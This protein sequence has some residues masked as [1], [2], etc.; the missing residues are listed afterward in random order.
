MRL[1]MAVLAVC[2]IAGCG[3][4]PKEKPPEEGTGVIEVTDSAT[5]NV[6]TLNFVPPPEPPGK[7]GPK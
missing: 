2:V 1:V 7:G 5:T 6:D 4:A 3:S